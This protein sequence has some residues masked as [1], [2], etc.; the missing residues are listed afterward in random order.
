LSFDAV[1]PRGEG[2]APYHRSSW[3]SQLF[4]RPKIFWPISAGATDKID[5]AR[6]VNLVAFDCYIKTYAEQ[7]DPTEEERVTIV[8]LRSFEMNALLCI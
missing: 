8:Y 3:A 6:N 4:L 1:A 5:G 2:F 7:D